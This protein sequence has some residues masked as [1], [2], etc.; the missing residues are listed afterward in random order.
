MQIWRM[1]PDGSEPVQV[2]TDAGQHWFPHVSPDGSQVVFLSYDPSVPADKHPPGKQVTIRVMPTS[3]GTAR[4]VAYVYGGQG[5][6]N[7]P[8]WSPD[9]RRIAFVSYGQ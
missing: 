9:S 4:V 5:T 2:T 7:V 1:N 8:S 3:G 6:L